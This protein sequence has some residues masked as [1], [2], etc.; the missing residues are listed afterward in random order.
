MLFGLARLAGLRVPSESNQVTWS[1]IDWARARIT[2]RSPK[3]ER[4]RGHEQRIVPITPKL[5]VI[6]QDAFDAAEP[7][8]DR[9][10]TIRGKGAVQRR[11][12]AIRER[13]GVEPWSRLWQTLRSSCEKQWAGRFPQYAVSRWIGHSITVSG[14]HYVNSVPDE[15]FDQAAELGGPAGALQNAQQHAAEQARTGSQSHATRKPPTT[16][17]SNQCK[18]MREHA[19]TDENPEKWSRGELNP[20][21]VT[22]ELPPLH[23]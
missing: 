8:Q 21:P 14:R 11:V 5:M 1:D 6:L 23:A 16:R 10:V 22:A 9:L 3:T 12:Q 17:K 19:P 18:T 4:H 13:A 20:R 15:L 7:G 2:V